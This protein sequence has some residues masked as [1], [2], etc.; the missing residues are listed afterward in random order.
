[1]TKKPEPKKKEKKKKQKQPG[2]FRENVK[3]IL[4][5]L[6]YVIF[7]N[8]FL[9]QS[10][11]IPTSSMEDHM[12]VGDHLLVNKICFTKPANFIESFILPQEKIKR[13]SIVIFKSPPQIKAQDW[14]RLIYVK[15][16]IGLPGETIQVVNN[17]VFINGQPIE[18]SY[19]NFKGDMTV[20]PNFPPENPAYWWSD[21]PLE[22][23]NCL[24]QTTGGTAFKIPAHHYFCMGDNRNVSADSRIWGPLPAEYVIGK[25]WRN[26]W[27]FEATT[28]YYLQ[29][30][31]LSRLKDMIVN[32]VKKTRWNRIL[33]K[34]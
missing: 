4:E 14:S 31:I 10:F 2:A 6:V 25:P 11:G 23:R 34:F 9:I 27:S 17:Q 20:P 21:F 22:Y 3:M 13:G 7:L 29:R 16:V 5:V 18:E 15:R 19:A 30:N 26:Y 8:A 1:M 32:F 28:E 24:V 33:K 12:L